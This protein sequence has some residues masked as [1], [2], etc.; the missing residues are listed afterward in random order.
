[1]KL[2]ALKQYIHLRTQLTHERQR[3]TARIQEIDKAL[4]NHAAAPAPKAPRV[5]TRSPR[6]ATLKPRARKRVKNAIS[7]KKA[8]LK[9]TANNP[10][11]K[12]DIFAA[13]RKLGWTTTSKKP[14]KMLDV[15]LYG[16]NP[17][18]KNQGGKFSPA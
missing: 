2:D 10:L 17:K 14:Q 11:T 1:M 7:L 4:G 15:L 6:V 5:Q 3:L 8:V 12:P 13:I 16:K 18:F 9:V